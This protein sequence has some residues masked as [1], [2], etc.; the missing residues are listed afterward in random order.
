[1]RFNSTRSF[2]LRLSS[3]QDF[4]L[5]SRFDEKRAETNARRRMLLKA[6]PVLL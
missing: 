2:S 6:H 5:A 3:A 4:L 1:M